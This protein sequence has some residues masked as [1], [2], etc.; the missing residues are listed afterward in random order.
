MTAEAEDQEIQPGRPR[1]KPSPFGRELRRL[2][3]LA[4]WSAPELAA[5]A[6]VAKASVTHYTNGY[7]QYP[8]MSSLIGISRALGVPIAHW[9]RFVR[10]DRRLAAKLA[11][12][13]GRAE[14][15]GAGPVDRLIGPAAGLEAL[16]ARGLAFTQLFGDHA[17]LLVRRGPVPA[18]RTGVYKVDGRYKVSARPRGETVGELVAVVSGE[19]PPAA[20][21][22]TGEEVSDG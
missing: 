17:L 1:P 15:P 13:A 2:L 22:L 12:E 16:P 6:E 8:S 7:R 19:P 21:P 10:G 11:R 20:G 18:G 9:Q 3:D 4:G 14:I 5:R